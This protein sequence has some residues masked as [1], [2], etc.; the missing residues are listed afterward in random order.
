MMEDLSRV[1]YKTAL[2]LIKYIPWVIAF[3][4]LI[5]LILSCFGI[6]CILIS[7]LT[8]LSVLPALCL[9]SFSVLFKF[10]IWD[11]L[12]IY[13]T[14]TQNVINAIDFYFSIPVSN[15]QM[16]FVYLFI[17]GIFILIGAYLKNKYN[18]QTRISKK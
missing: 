14:L 2:L 5:A 12:P 15:L 6:Q 18:E 9:I 7:F 16:I 8:H 3:L 11:R 1:K 4:T 17:S 10:C 13:Y